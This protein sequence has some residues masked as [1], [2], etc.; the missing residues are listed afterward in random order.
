MP[1][2][3]KEAVLRALSEIKDP[4]LGQ[5][6]VELKRV[7]SVKAS[8]KK[9]DVVITLVGA[10]EDTQ[11]KMEADIHS[12]LK[13]FDEQS[14]SIQ[15]RDQ[16]AGEAPAPEMFR[17]CAKHVIL[18]ASGK[19]GVGKSTVAVNLAAALAKSG[20]AVGLV[21]AD[22]YGPSVPV[23]LGLD[24]HTEPHVTWVDGQQKLLPFYAH[25][26]EVMSIGLM[27]PPYVAL[28]WRGP[29]IHKTLNQ[30]TD[31]V[32]WGDLDFLIMD[33]PPGTGDVQLTLA[34]QL[35]IAGAVVVTT[36][37]RV[38]LADVIRAQVFFEQLEVPVLGV[39]ENMSYFLC[40]ECDAR[41]EL[42]S[43]GGGAQTA[44]RFDLP[45]LAEIPMY[46]TL[47]EWADRGIPEVIADPDSP[48]A[49]A[50]FELAKT[51]K[52]SVGA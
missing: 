8:A 39:V 12:A 44:K 48:A 1:I 20:A 22:V 16:K 41:H 19:G 40:T 38:A 6:I 7:H 30:F 29:M 18:V 33:L 27:V 51:V 35:D 45:L 24:D 13:A 32:A 3:D 23:M 10:S 34:Q 14:L 4:I 26:M 49:L 52:K 43:H 9:I 42:F 11:K 37:Q 5:S 47:R 46:P 25:D 36:P 17:Q 28:P 21:D 31:D 2:A 15:I 50:F